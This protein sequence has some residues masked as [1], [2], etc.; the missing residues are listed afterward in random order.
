MKK[1]KIF[2]FLI[3][4]ALI[5]NN[6]RTVQDAMDPQRKDNTDEFLVEKKSPLSMPP[7]FEKLPVPKN[8]KVVEIEENN[9]KKLI[10]SNQTNSSETSNN[11]EGDLRSF[12][13]ILIEKIKKN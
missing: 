13:K 4:A 5:L 2:L 9:L 1:I 10:D 12:E 3:I 6:C 7:D 11:N 8:E